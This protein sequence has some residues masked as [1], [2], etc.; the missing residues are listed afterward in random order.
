MAHPELIVRRLS[1][2]VLF[3]FSG[4]AEGLAL[5]QVVPDVGRGLREALSEM[6]GRYDFPWLHQ[7]VVPSKGI[8]ELG[9]SWEDAGRPQ[10]VQ[11]VTRSVWV[12]DRGQEL[13]D[14]AKSRSLTNQKSCFRPK[15]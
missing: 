10:E 5:L 9:Y 15:S 6:D 12:E 13:L 4:D 2:E 7:V 1:G 8:L 3:Q 14:H 11:I